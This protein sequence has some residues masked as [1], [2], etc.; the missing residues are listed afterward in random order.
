MIEL[1]V[2]VGGKLEVTIACNEDR[3]RV[4]LVEAKS[5]P[6]V[7]RIEIEPGDR[8]PT[9]LKRSGDRWVTI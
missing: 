1:K 3:A 8:A 9:T 7:D 6:E 4:E 2:Y 5:R